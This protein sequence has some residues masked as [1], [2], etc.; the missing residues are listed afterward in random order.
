MSTEAERSKSPEVPKESSKPNSTEVALADLSLDRLHSELKSNPEKY[1]RD[2]KPLDYTWDIE[3]QKNAVSYVQSQIMILIAIVWIDLSD[4]QFSKLDLAKFEE[5]MW[6]KKSISIPES[7]SVRGMDPNTVYGELIK[8]R[9]TPIGKYIIGKWDEMKKVA[10]LARQEHLEQA[11]RSPNS[12]NTPI[13]ITS[14]TGTTLPSGPVTDNWVWQQTKDFVGDNKWK[15]ALVGGWML[16]V[17]AAFRLFGGE[18]SKDESKW[19]S[20][21][22]DWKVLAVAGFATWFGLYKWGPDWVRGS[23]EKFTAFLGIDKASKIEPQK[24]KGMTDLIVEYNNKKSPN[25]QR[26]SFPEK[27]IKSKWGMK[28]SEFK[29]KDGFFSNVMYTANS[30]VSWITGTSGAL[31]H[32][33]KQE[34]TDYQLLLDYTKS[35]VAEYNI[36]TTDD[37]LMDDIWKQIIEKEGKSVT[38]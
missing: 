29:D 20:G 1:L 37:M 18:G 26:K 12:T 4:D 36:S 38:K 3:K 10:T 31:P 23:F 14:P 28:A 15:I 30:A 27:L 2:I 6:N 25:D 32:D 35:K 16:A 17:Y 19:F 33:M 24:I 22:T 7:L 11:K 13:P 9:T 8:N 21:I 5:I 34:W